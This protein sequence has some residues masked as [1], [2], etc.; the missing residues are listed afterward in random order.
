MSEFGRTPRF[1]SGRGKDH[2]P[3]T[4]SLV[5]GSGVNG[6]K[7]LG[8]TDDAL[9]GVPVDFETGQANNSGEM[10]G[11]ENLGVAL[12]KLGGLDPEQI[13]PGIQPFNAILK[14]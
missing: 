7:T 6:G 12:L 1:N 10:L 3:F 13:L 8:A 9:I 5:I 4:S 11:S 2:W 14:S